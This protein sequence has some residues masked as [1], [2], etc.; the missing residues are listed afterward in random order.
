MSAAKLKAE[1]LPDPKHSML[2]TCNRVPGD[3]TTQIG[4]A[5]ATVWEQNGV[6]FS[7]CPLWEKNPNQSVV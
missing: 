5:F 1:I 3:T 6:S 7:Y 4:H 2:V